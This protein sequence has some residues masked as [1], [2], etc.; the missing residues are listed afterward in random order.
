MVCQDITVQLDATGNVSITT[1]DIDNGSSD[2]CS[3]VTLS[4]DITAFT[5]AEIGANTV[6]LTGTDAE[7]NSASC[8]ATVTVEE[9]VPPVMACQ[10][11]TVQ[12]DASGN[13]TIVPADIDNG[14]ADACSAVTLSLD[15]SAFTCADVG[16]NTV[17]LTGT[18]VSGNSASCTAT[19]TVEDNVD[20]TAVCMDIT[21]NLDGSGNAKI[22]GADVDGGSTDNCA[23]ASLSVTPNAFTSADLGVNTVTLTVT[24][25]NGNTSTCTADVTVT[26]LTPP[27][28]V[29]QDITVNLDASGN[30]TITGADIDGGSSDNGTIV[31]LVASPNSFIVLTPVQT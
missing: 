25:V 29:C 30:V 2:A 26:D 8:T 31:S 19:V 22:V 18:D 5:C 17:T 12:L 28:A 9:N 4:L 1:G 27:T 3:A 10:D 24:D 14:S 6:T 11:I 16:A 13:A 15:V 20:P 23:I 7:G 21:V